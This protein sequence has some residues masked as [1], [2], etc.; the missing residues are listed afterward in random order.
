MPRL[1][2]RL[3]TAARLQRQAQEG[4]QAQLRHIR[5]NLEQ[6]RAHMIQTVKFSQLRKD[7]LR[8]LNHYTVMGRKDYMGKLEARKSQQGT[9]ENQGFVH[10]GQLLLEHR[11][12]QG[13]LR[14][15]PQGPFNGKSRSRLPT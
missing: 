5:R 12:M 14:L 4:L 1:H 8:D 15:A 6:L 9:S 13:L 7:Q 3:P 10:L 11:P 2:P